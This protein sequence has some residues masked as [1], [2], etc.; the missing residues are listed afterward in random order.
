MLRRG[1]TTAVCVAS[2][3]SFSQA[4]ADL[5]NASSARV[6]AVNDCYRRLPNADVLYACDWNWWRLHI[7][8][9]RMSFA[10]ER[11]THV[12]AERLARDKRYALEHEAMVGFDL[13]SVTMRL[14]KNELLPHDDERITG[15]SNSGFQAIQLA[16]I[17]GA[18]RI[19]LVGFDC[20]RTG[21]DAHFFG[22]HPKGL[23]NSDPT[24]FRK[25]FDTIAEPLRL[26][27]TEVINCSAATALECFPRADLAACL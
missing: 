15:V 4:Q 16:R 1:W 19:L 5:I 10:G 24:I 9:V 23:T 3:P 13:H 17:F 27:G 20:Q 11:W 22:L 18:T 7:D 25:H 26:E 14:G 8:A 21:G 12:N 2:G 6:I